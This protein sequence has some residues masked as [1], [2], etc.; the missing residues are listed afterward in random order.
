M[1]YTGS[2][3]EDEIQK[4]KESGM[5]EVLEKPATFESLHCLIKHVF[6]AAKNINKVFSCTAKFY[7]LLSI[8]I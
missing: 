7:W 2:L 5:D 1:G 8:C 3:G 4:C 6:L